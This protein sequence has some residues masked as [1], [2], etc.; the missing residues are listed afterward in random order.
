MM[1][2]EKTWDKLLQI[3]TTGRDELGADDRHHPYEP[4]PYC[5]P[6]RLVG[7]RFL[8]FWTMAVEK[9][10]LVFSCPGGPKPGPL[11]LQKGEA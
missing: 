5:V 1:D 3:K 7:S 11:E 6:E 4:T 10:G 9:A 8:W 2:K